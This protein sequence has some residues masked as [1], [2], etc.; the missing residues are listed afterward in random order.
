MVEVSY[1]PAW[2]YSK[3]MYLSFSGFFHQKSHLQI[4]L[5]RLIEDE[6]RNGNLLVEVWKKI[7][8]YY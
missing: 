1:S 3:T 5:E 7:L 4:A 8:F 6:E 2:F